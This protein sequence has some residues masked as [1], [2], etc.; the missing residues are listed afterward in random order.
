MKTITLSNKK[1]S[2]EI[3][4]LAVGHG[5]IGHPDQG[6]FSR[7]YLDEYFAAGG[8]CI[9]TARLYGDG[10]C[11]RPVGEYI[12]K[13]PRDKVVV[14]TKCAHYDYHV[15]PIVHRLA[16]DDIRFDIN[17]SLAELDV[18]YIDVMFLH[19]DD[20]RRPVEEIMS[21]LHEFVKAGKVRMLGASNW[22]AGRI[23]EANDF[24][25]TNG[26]TPF[27]VSQIQYSLAVTT[28]GVTDDLSHVIMDNIEYHWYKDN[29]FPVMCWSATGHG[30]FSKL[31]NGEEQ[32][33]W[34]RKRYN[35]TQENYRRFERI[36]KLSEE[37]N[38]PVGTLAVSYLMSDEDV[39][40]IP[41]VGFSSAEQ[42]EETMLAL[43]VH[44]TRE[45]RRFLETGE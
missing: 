23:K 36:K 43:N 34:V 9:D 41:I 5:N 12:K 33:E 3:S 11:E 2:L 28:P 13:Y 39:P 40:T 32:R 45:Q 16:P 21:T 19:R 31:A 4:Q 42:F 17:T 37:L 7:W 25:N 14:I 22:T 15:H 6:K 1:D 29:N 30:F 20:I 38:V 10:T 18:D 24:A 8:N 27:S 44:L 26:L 35:W